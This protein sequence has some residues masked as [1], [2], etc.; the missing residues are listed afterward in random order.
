MVNGIFMHSIVKSYT[1][2]YG[3]VFYTVID[4]PSKTPF[5]AYNKNETTVFY[6]LIIFDQFELAKSR[7]PMQW[8]NWIVLYN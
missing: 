1:M 7:R 4:R 5:L 3:S 8:E 2:F 6:E